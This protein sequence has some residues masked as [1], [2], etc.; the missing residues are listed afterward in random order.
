ME[1]YFNKSFFKLLLTF[2]AILICSLAVFYLVNVYA[3]T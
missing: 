2:L 3:K 1:K